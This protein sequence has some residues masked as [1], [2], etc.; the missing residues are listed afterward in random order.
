MTQL[1]DLA[2]ALGADYCTVG[3]DTPGA[4]A[5]PSAAV[6]GIDLRA[7]EIRPGD[8]FAALPGAHSHGAGYV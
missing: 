2:A 7:Q 4:S 8:L 6:T 1:R 5:E 3:P